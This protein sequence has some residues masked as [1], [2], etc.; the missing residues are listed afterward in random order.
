MFRKGGCNE[1]FP[2]DGS[3][4]LLFNLLELDWRSDLLILNGFLSLRVIDEGCRT[5]FAKV[6]EVTQ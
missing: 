1:G 5:G 2:R 3:I 4:E 6:L